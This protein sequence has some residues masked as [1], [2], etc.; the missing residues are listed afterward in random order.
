MTHVSERVCMCVCTGQQTPDTGA[1]YPVASYTLLF[2]LLIAGV[3][4]VCAGQHAPG[5]GGHMHTAP[6]ADADAAA[7][8]PGARQQQ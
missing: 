7:P 3:V 6:S 5:A 1:M 8:L 2:A 4:F